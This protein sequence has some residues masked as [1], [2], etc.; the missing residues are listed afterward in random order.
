MKGTKISHHVLLFY[1]PQCTYMKLEIARVK[2]TDINTGKHTN[3]QNCN[4]A[5]MYMGHK[6]GGRDT[7]VIHGAT[8]G[9]HNEG[10]WGLLGK[11]QMAKVKHILSSTNAYTTSG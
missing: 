8:C 11:V 1:C 4:H 2:Y 6:I 9:T 3:A 10:R 5:P 7:K